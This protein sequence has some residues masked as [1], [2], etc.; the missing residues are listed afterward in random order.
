MGGD[1]AVGGGGVEAKARRCWQWWL[2]GENDGNDDKRVKNE[3]LVCDDKTSQ[4]GKAR[5]H[6][7][8]R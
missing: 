6:P 7:G 4:E 3:K 1:P 8:R 2:W 5:A